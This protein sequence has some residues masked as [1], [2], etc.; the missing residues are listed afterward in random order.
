V[1]PNAQTGS[2]ASAPP[3]GVTL[4]PLTP[5]ASGPP[6]GVTLTP[7]TGSP[8][9]SPAAPT[10]PA[11]PAADNTLTG[12]P[13]GEGTYQMTGPN[14]DTVKVPYS[15]VGT[16]AHDQGYRLT[17]EST[18]F[19][20]ATGDAARYWNDYAHD[21]KTASD[22]QDFYKAVQDP[23]Q[24]AE[25][26]AARG[27]ALTAAGLA[28]IVRKVTGTTGSTTGV[29]KSAQK[30]GEGSDT[31]A[32]DFGKFAEGV[33]EFLMGDEYLKGLSYVQ[34]LKQIEPV[35]KVMD[36]SPLLARIVST[37]MRQAAVAGAQT[38]AKTGGDARQAAASGVGTA[39]LT[40][41]AEGV[42]ARLQAPKPTPA[43]TGAERY[44]AE[45]RAAVEPQLREAQTAMDSQV[46][47]A[48]GR[49]TR[50]ASSSGTPPTGSPSPEAPHVWDATA[51]PV[52]RA[53]AEAAAR[54]GPGI[55]SGAGSGMAT[56]TGVGEYSG[57]A[58]NGL[59]P[60][61][62]L[63]P[64]LG[65]PVDTSQRGLPSGSSPT[66]LSEAQRIVANRANNATSSAAQAE[67]AKTANS[68]NV[69]DVLNTIHDFNGAKDRLAQVAAPMYDAIDQVTG[70]KFRTLN[71]EVAAAQRAVYKSVAGTP[72]RAA[73]EKLADSRQAEMS[74][75]IDSTSGTVNPQ[76]VRAAK[77]AFRQSYLLDDVAT[78]WDRNL[79]GVPGNTKASA[80]Q[81]GVNGKGLLRDLTS[82]V[83]R[84]GRP[85]V[86]SVLGVGRLDNL[87][88]IA[89]A[90]NTAAKKVAF[91]E[92]VRNVARNLA[93]GAI[94]GSVAGE[95][96]GNRAAGGMIGTGI[97]A[98]SYIPKVLRAIAADPRIG[99]QLTFALKSGA[100][101]EN[102]GPLIANMIQ[103]AQQKSQAE[104][105]QQEGQ[106]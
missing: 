17:G 21:P 22:A 64:H 104:D 59:A 77:N 99:Q 7:L 10:T 19:H 58:S 102:Y 47:N 27:A 63:G 98:A 81:R 91:G 50:G 40:P 73:A 44:A 101:P 76:I 48:A 12:N 31:G 79:D 65:E 20:G 35:I 29:E 97:V 42:S 61:N 69:N 25:I 106:P 83:N 24:G 70:G 80:A 56:R 34:R 67:S 51:T 13:K 87:E 78:I 84:K 90:N 39:L 60:R 6:P 26:G 30:F 32:E 46:P 82:T 54:G 8:A 74:A 57:P 93:H 45:A 43:M 4:T 28:H 68:F 2:T 86:E 16:I 105:T 38:Y 92:A 14:G 49:A 5:T 103:A 37:A 3:P 89:N 1:D 95:V 75:L 96:A 18:F 72:E 85:F 52:Q 62:G 11:A 36:K 88:E 66:E 55:A 33:G 9:P 15:K 41:L 71:A 100:R 94:A 23:G 53:A